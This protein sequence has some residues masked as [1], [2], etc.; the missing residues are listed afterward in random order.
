M[1]AIFNQP[2][3]VEDSDFF[4][5]AMRLS[6]FFLCFFLRWFHLP[7]THGMMIIIDVGRV[8]EMFM[9]EEK[10]IDQRAFELLFRI[11]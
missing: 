4:A 8:Y 2:E 5:Q 3:I 11:S 1:Y 10:S 6:I 7:L 9:M